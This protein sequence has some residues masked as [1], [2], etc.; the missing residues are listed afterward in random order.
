MLMWSTLVPH[1]RRYGVL[2]SYWAVDMLRTRF[3]LSPMDLSLLT[4]LCMVSDR[5]K[6]IINSMQLKNSSSLQFGKYSLHNKL[7]EFKDAGYIVR[8]SRD[9]SQPYL[10]R[11]ISRQKIFIQ[12]TGKGVE[13]ID[14]IERELFR[15]T[16]NSSLA[17]VTTVQ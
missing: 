2:Y 6:Y 12:F 9:P 5:G 4:Y 10:T 3:G 16:V 15:I 11:S 1:G 7:I 13:L 8:L 14:K 17:N